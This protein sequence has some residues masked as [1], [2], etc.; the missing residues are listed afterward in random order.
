MEGA[1][2]AGALYPLMI[3]NSIRVWQES[4][5]RG[6]RRISPDTNRIARYDECGDVLRQCRS[7]TRNAGERIGLLTE[8]RRI[9]FEAKEPIK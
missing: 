4:I 1:V 9:T 5:R 8:Q 7:F 2:Q 6:R 3:L